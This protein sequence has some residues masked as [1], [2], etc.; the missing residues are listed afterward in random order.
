MP[1]TM[2]ACS[3][4]FSRM[5][6]KQPWG[7][8]CSS[9]YNPTNQ[10]EAQQTTHGNDNY[11]RYCQTSSLNQCVYMHS[12]VRLQPE[13]DSATQSD[14]CNCPSLHAGWPLYVTSN[15]KLPRHSRKMAY[16]ER[17]QAPSVYI[18][19]MITQTR[20]TMALFLSFLLWFRR[21]DVTVL[22]LPARNTGEK[23]SRLHRTQ[24]PIWSDGT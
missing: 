10:H 5:C 20:C 22:L 13:F 1:P 12:L 19:Y 6:S 2:L 18:S 17:D 3:L 8:K 21:K 7:G 11:C 15:N 9:E 16:E 14:Y 23:M 4:R 24:N